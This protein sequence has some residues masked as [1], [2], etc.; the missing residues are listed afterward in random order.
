MS[1]IADAFEIIFSQRD[2]IF[3]IGTFSMG[4]GIVG[5]ALEAWKYRNY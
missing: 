1:L 5:T 2:V 3:I 4:V